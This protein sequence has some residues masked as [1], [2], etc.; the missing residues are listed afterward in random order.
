M[1][2]LNSRNLQ[3]VI[4][5]EISIFDVATLTTQLKLESVQINSIFQRKNG[6]ED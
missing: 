5:Q 4:G 1:L 6:T 2:F 3:I